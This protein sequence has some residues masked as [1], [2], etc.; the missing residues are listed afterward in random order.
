MLTEVRLD[1]EILRFAQNDIGWPIWSAMT[2]FILFRD[3]AD[4]YFYLLVFSLVTNDFMLYL[5]H[6]EVQLYLR[7]D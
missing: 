4:I 7:L 1:R 2:V 3:N 6:G 5:Y